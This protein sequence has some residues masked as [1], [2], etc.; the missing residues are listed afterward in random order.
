MFLNCF[1]I[2]DICLIN[3][4]QPEKT[5]K[6]LQEKKMTRQDAQY[7]LPQGK[8]NSQNIGNQEQSHNEQ[9]LLP[10]SP[11][12]VMIIFSYINAFQINA[13]VHHEPFICLFL[14]FAA[15][16]DFLKHKQPHDS[17]LQWFCFMFK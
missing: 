4:K 1:L 15:R 11:M 9:V 8:C 17:P 10:H 7:I 6:V 3:S 13:Y 5:I 14:I 2:E 12:E 16:E